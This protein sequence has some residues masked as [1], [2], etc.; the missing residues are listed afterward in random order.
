MTL[1]LKIAAPVVILA[2]GFA[3]ARWLNETAPQV[4]PQ[5][6]ETV[7]PLVEIL[8]VQSAPQTLEVQGNGEVRAARHVQLVA[9]VSARVNWVAPELETGDFVRS[10]APLLRFDRTD[11]ELALASAEAR[12]AQSMAALQ[13]EEAEAEIARADWAEHGEGPPPALVAREPQLARAQADVRAAQAA[14]DAALRDLARCEVRAPFDA[15][16]ESRLVTVASF[17][18]P[19]QALCQLAD[20]AAAEVTV[21]V[22]LADL[23]HLELS[24]GADPR[25]LTVALDAQVAGA[26]ASWTGEVVRTGASLDP[27]N[28][29]ASLIVRVDAPYAGKTPLIPGT[30]VHARIQGR[31]VPSLHR[32][33]RSALR[34]DS[35]VLIL[36]AQ[37]QLEI[38]SVEVLQRTGSEALI[39]A[40]LRDGDQLI[41]TPLVTIV[42]GMTLRTAS[43][44]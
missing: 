28:R 34:D 42:P 17:V 37:N 25:A 29:M 23:A 11:Y 40:G 35:T 1:I 3:G 6:P 13:L 38:R 27:L 7:I 36:D 41:L 33:P 8:P 44:E 16:V 26:P 24:L 10:G 20:S 31:L 30:F 19:G 2:S 4:P 22:R 12:L 15:R 39:D 5:V 18:G 43:A 14:V 9:E 21:P 32:I